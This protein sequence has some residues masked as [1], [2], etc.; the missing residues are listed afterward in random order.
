MT[1]GVGSAFGSME[2]QGLSLRLLVPLLQLPGHL[3]AQFHSRVRPAAQ[4]ET[5]RHAWT[6]R[7]VCQRMMRT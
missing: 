2:Y 4:F 6:F 3:V 1:G 5:V 7:I